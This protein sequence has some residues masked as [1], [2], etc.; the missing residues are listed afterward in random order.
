MARAGLAEYHHSIHGPNQKDGLWREVINRQ[1]WD[2]PFHPLREQVPKP[3][4]A[5]NI[6]SSLDAQSQPWA[7]LNRSFQVGKDDGGTAFLDGRLVPRG[8]PQGRTAGPGE[9][10]QF[11][12]HDPRSR[13]AHTLGRGLRASRS[14]GELQMSQKFAATRGDLRALAGRAGAARRRPP[15][16]PGFPPRQVGQGRSTTSCRMLGGR[17]AIACPASRGSTTLE[18]REASEGRA[19]GI[20]DAACSLRT[21]V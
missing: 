21:H 10:A 5:Q 12:G 15:C 18:G 4:F 20:M 19:F 8:L 1:H 3:S 13:N 2:H 6:P 7:L 17:N 11:S 16:A 9:A 14:S